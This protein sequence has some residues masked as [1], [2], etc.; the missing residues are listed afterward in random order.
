MIRRPP[1]STL[2]PY[3][4]LFRSAQ[5]PRLKKLIEAQ[6]AQAEKQYQ[7]T[8]TA[9]RVFTEFFYATEKTWGRERRG[10]SQTQHFGKRANP[11]LVGSSLSSAPK[12][13]PEV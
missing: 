13:A 8:K 1:R 5:N 10:I 6:M 9:A 4:T 12:A 3:T 7:E 2:F 11:R